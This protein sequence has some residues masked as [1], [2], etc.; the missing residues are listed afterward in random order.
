MTIPGDLVNEE[1]I[2]R[3]VIVRGGPVS[4]GYS[5]SID[6]EN[7][8]ILNSHILA[9]LRKE[10]KNKMNFK[11]DLKFKEST[12]GEIRKHEEQTARLIGSFKQ[13]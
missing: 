4:G 2:N 6:T 7:D 9:K 11:A 5:T 8:F 13:F 1:A 12:P 3:E 10:F